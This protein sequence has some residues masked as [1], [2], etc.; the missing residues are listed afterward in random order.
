MKDEAWNRSVAAGLRADAHGL[1]RWAWFVLL[2]L[3]ATCRTPAGAQAVPDWENPRVVGVHKLPARPAGW[4]APDAATALRTTYGNFTASP[5]VQC[6]SGA[7][8]FHWVKEPSARPV[9]FFKT[10]FDATSWKTIPVPG[11]W[12][13]YG[14]GTPIYVNSIY[15]FKVDQPRVMGEPDHRYTAFTE[16]NPVGS[17]RQK[18]EIPAAWMGQRIYLH[19]AGVCSAMYV[20]V[21]GQKVGFSKDSMLPAEFDITDLVRA[22]SNL[23]ACEVY[24]YSD[25]SY[26]EDQDMWRLSGIQ[27][28]VWVF[29]KPRQQVWDFLV[30][31]ELDGTYRD[32]SLKL[33][34]TVNNTA[35]GPATG[36]KLHLELL[37]AAGQKVAS[38]DEA[39]PEVAAGAS[40]SGTAPAL[41]VAAPRHWTPETPN[42]YTAVLELRQGSAVLETLTQRVGFRKV[43]LRDKQFCLNGQ[44]LKIKGVCRHEHDPHT[45]RAITFASMVQDVRLMKQANFNLVRTSHY[46]NDPRWYDLCDEY[47]LMVLDEANVESHGLSYHRRILPGDRPEW[48]EPVVDRMRRMVLRDRSHASIVMWSLGN[49]AGFGDAFVAMAAECRRLDPQHRPL[50]YADMNLPCDVD[51]QTYPTPEWLLQHVQGK[52]VRKGEQGQKS[53]PAQHGPYPS[54]RPFFMNE[55]AW[56]GGNSLGN[57]QDYWDV[58]EAHPMLI[59]GCIWQWADLALCKKAADGR[60]FFAYGGDFGDY[61]N[62][63]VFSCNGIVDPLHHPR[64]AYFEAQK[65]QQYIKV[66]PVDAGAGRIKVLNKYGFTN[67]NAFDALWELTADGQRV[68]SGTLGQIDI[69]P[70]AAQEVTVPVVKP[71][72]LHGAEYHLKVSFQLS[73]AQRWADKGFVVAWDQITVPWQGGGASAAPAAAV[74][75]AAQLSESPA[76]LELHAADVVARIGRQSGLLESFTVGGRQMLSTPLGFNF[77]RVPTEDDRGWKVPKNSLPWKDAGSGARLQSIGTV[78]AAPERME[79]H[80][81]FA[82]PVG[83]TTAELTYGMDGTGALRVTYRLLPAGKNL[84]LLVRVG[85]QGALPA[86]LQHVTWFGR[87][88]QESYQ[89][90]QTGAAVGIY[91]STVAQWIHGYIRPQENANR[92]EVRWA[93]FTDDQGAGLEFAAAG[94]PLN[95]SAWPYTLADLEA[96]AHDYQLPRRDS[97]TVNIDQQQMGLGGDTGWG[98]PVHKQYCLPADQ[99]YSYSFK[100]VPVRP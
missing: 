52:A 14:Y 79:I 44:A 9:D 81:A 23:L 18:F 94:A 88:P 8:Q 19:F 96:A 84:P 62:D 55:Y 17:Y 67:L 20:W 31:T 53:F 29:C 82:I 78:H 27:R 90:R 57:F 33:H 36:L 66:M 25:S 77:W 70:G 68:Q 60:E 72:A 58:I 65:V 100:I 2:L 22:G 85:M 76:A 15:P 74:A 7:W 1:L 49:E 61:P 13:L 69:A 45:G 5:W 10:D 63:G 32:G 86:P 43:E 64:P 41:A 46:P 34:Y 59:G 47:G 3:L 71:A 4:A 38:Q 40:F 92:T 95:V 28:D 89:D 16:R 93:R 98:L 83:Q 26:I 6:L 24:C 37:D 99:P 80:A 21:N 30:E 51:S 48:Q 11:N 56:S 87:G 75:G 12:Q 50:Q 39:L 42:L 97:V 73:Q 35:A 54:G 91:Q